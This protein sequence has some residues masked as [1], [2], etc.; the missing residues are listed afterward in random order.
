MRTIIDTAREM[1]L[2]LS[3]RAAWEIGAAARDL[4]EA[5]YGSPP[6]KALRPKTNGGGSHCFAI[7]PDEFQPHIRRLIYAVCT[8][9]AAQRDL[10]RSEGQDDDAER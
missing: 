4:Y 3:D 7:Y 5:T 8:R 2:E 1:D 9:R 10:F 6:P